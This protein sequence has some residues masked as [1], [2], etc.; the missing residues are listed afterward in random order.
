MSNGTDISIITKVTDVF[1]KLLGKR[2]FDPFNR[3]KKDSKEN[4]KSLFSND[5][6]EFKLKY[7]IPRWKAVIG[8]LNKKIYTSVKEE[9]EK[10][11]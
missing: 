5:K 6:R 3:K 11:Q 10:C 9:I 4:Q 2:K 1:K 7:H 8:S